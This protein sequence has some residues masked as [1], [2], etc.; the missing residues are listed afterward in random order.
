MRKG[1]DNHGNISWILREVLKGIG[2]EVDQTFRDPD[3]SDEELTPLMLANIL[4]KENMIEVLVNRGAAP[5]A[6]TN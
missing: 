4:G 6:V 1:G 5:V 2:R 3:F